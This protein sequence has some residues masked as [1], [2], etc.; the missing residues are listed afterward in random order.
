[1]RAKASQFIVEKKDSEKKAENNL[2]KTI[3]QSNQEGFGE[4]EILAKL[5]KDKK[6]LNPDILRAMLN[7]SS[8]KIKETSFSPKQK[9]VQSVGEGK[10]LIGGKIN[11]KKPHKFSVV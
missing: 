8:V 1:M 3:K 9:N 7:P 5:N 2:T 6:K 10:K 4:S 11:K